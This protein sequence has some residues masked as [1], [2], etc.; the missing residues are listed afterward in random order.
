M[1]PFDFCC[2]TRIV[3]GPGRVA[4]TGAL[5][6]SLAVRRA[7][8]VSDP[9]IVRA[10]HTGRCVA[11]LQAAGLEAHV[12]DA[13]QENP[14]TLEVEAGVRV[15]RDFTPDVL[16]AVGGGSSMDC[17][18]GINFL[19]SCGGQMQDYWGVG[20]ATGP[21]LP[22]V[23]VPTTAGTGSEAQSFALISDATTHAKMACG[24]KRA[25]FRLA[26][27][28]PE[29]TLTQPPRVTALTGID[30]V[31]HTIETLVCKKRNQISMA[32]SREAWRLLSQG[33]PRVLDDP[34]D[35]IAR[36]WVQQGACL[37]GLAIEN[38]MLGAA[39]ALANPLTATYGVVHGE[40]VGVMLPHVVAHNASR[41]RG[42][43]RA[44]E[45]LSQEILPTDWA[46]PAA[47][48]LELERFLSDLA[49]KANLASTLE[50]LGVERD[51]LPAL[52]A[53]AARQWTGSFNPVEMSEDDYLRIYQAAYA[54]DAL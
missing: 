22:M 50:A 32:F 10:G 16:L 53:D 35:L 2:P 46:D 4:E 48:C 47:G 45:E 43:Q 28:D 49:R 12:F 38:S 34:T 29:L 8:V 23:A 33:L 13:V 5:T 54:G 30:A 52:A 9:G 25:A 19:Y 3:F 1:T 37:A 42:A 7:L 39:H 51:R 18:K 20:K 11:L 15:A 40:A 26:I 6:A 27:L 14:T 41:S 17:C 31:A 36:A 24:D 21:L 44:Y